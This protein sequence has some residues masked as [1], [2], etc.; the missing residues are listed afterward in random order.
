MVAYPGFR[1]RGD[2]E[3]LMDADEVVMGE[4]KRHSGPH[5]L[6]FFENALVNRVNRRIDIRM[7]RFCRST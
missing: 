1:G 6:D 4:V 2:P 7:V 3:S 5:V